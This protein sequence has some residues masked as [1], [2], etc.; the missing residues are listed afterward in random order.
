MKF[1]NTDQFVENVTAFESS[2]KSGYESE[3]F[4]D[5]L[6]LMTIENGIWVLAYLCI[7]FVLVEFFCYS[8]KLT[9]KCYRR[10]YHKS[11]TCAV[12]G[13]EMP[14]PPAPVGVVSIV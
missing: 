8:T 6:K 10:C 9:V 5:F 11:C 2:L 1:G 4:D 14:P 13:E 12:S 3:G 7:L